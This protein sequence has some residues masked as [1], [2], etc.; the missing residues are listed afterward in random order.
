M[1]SHRPRS[2][3]WGMDHIWHGW[4]TP[5]TT[6]WLLTTPRPYSAVTL[7]IGTKSFNNDPHQWYSVPI[8][9]MQVWIYYPT[10][11]GVLYEAWTMYDR[12]GSSHLLPHDHKLYPRHAQVLPWILEPRAW[13]MVLISGV[14]VQGWWCRYKYTIPPFYE[15]YISHGPRLIGVDHP[16]YHHMTSN[17]TPAIL[18][19]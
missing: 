7:D 11:L 2:V 5:Q 15:C 12:G 19:C 17:C 14:V 4:I 6:T 10:T 3:I 9:I 1:P 13:T 18:S 8:I 16:T